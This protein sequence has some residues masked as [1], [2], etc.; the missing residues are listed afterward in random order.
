MAVLQSDVSVPT[1]RIKIRSPNTMAFL[2]ETN[3]GTGEL[4][5]TEE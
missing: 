4:F 3:L 2:D 1:E 5:V